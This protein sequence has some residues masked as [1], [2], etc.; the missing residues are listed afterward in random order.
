MQK[1]VRKVLRAVANYDPGYYDM[2][3]DPNEAFFGRLYLEWILHHAAEA[4]IR[5]PGAVLDAGCQTGRLAVPLA[6]E[7]FRVTGID[8]SGFALRRAKHHA[9]IAGVTLTLEQGDIAEVLVDHPAL[10]V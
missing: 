9:K 8:T 6:Q 2:Y 7:G 1:T 10:A 5:S 4:G 3:A